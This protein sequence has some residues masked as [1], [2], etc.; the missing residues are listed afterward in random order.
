MG[1]LGGRYRIEAQLG[2]G[3]MGAVYWATDERTGEA[4]AVKRMLLERTRTARKAILRFQ[5]EF[6]TLASLR[7]PRV[8]RA[9]DYGVDGAGPYYTME[10]L[11]GEDLRDVMK[12]RGPLPPREVCRILRDVA[13]ALAALHARGLIH[14]DL[15]PRNVRVVDGRAVLFDFGVLVNAGWVGDVAG[16]PAFVAPEML[17]GVPVDGRADLYSLGVL[18]YGMLTGQ[19]PYDARSLADLEEAWTHPVAPPSAFADVPEALEDLVLDLLCLEP[20]GRPPSAAVLIDRLTSLGDLEADPELAVSPGYVESAAMVGRDAELRTLATLLDEVQ[21][22]VSRAFLVEADSGAGKSRLLQEVAIRAKL[23]GALALR[24]DCEHAEGGPFAAV[25]AIVDE[26]FG[27]DPERAAAATREGAPWLGRVFE[28][29]RRAHPDVALERESGEPAEDR[30][31]LSAAV[32]GALRRLADERPVA[33]LVD[34]VQRCDEASAAL[35]AGLARDGAPGMLLGFA[36]RLGESMRA[37]AAVASLGELE[38]RL[39][40]A[41]LDASGVEALLRSV[42]GDAPRLPRLSRWMLRATGGSPLFCT[43]LTRHLI[44]AGVV[45]YDDG[46]WIVPDELTQSGLP[47]GLAEAMRQRIDG[48]SP[49]SRQV[50]EVLAVHGGEVDLER[51]LGLVDGSVDLPDEEAAPVVFGAL[52]EM[53]QQGVLSDG[54]ERLSFRHDSLREAVLAG[55]A[56]ERRRA[57]HRHVGGVLLEAERHRDDP[58]A[59]AEAGWHLY[60]GGDEEGGAAMLERAGRR[61]YEAQALTDCIAPL[62][63]ALEVR[64]RAGAPDAVIAD[65]SFM[66]LSAGWVSDREVGARHADRAVELCA[67]LG[68]LEHTRRWRRWLGWRL[69]FACALS[70]AGLRWLF[71]W[72]E[73]RGPTPLRAV[74]LFA[75]GMTYATALAYAANQK[76]EVHR[77]IERAAPFRAFEGHPPVAA[78]L[79]VQAMGDILDGRLEL[80]STRLTEAHRLATRAHVNPLTEDERRLSDAAV[81]SIRTIVDVNQFD[82]RLYD[83][84]AALEAS[85]LE[86]YQLVAR[87]L[88]AVRHRYRGEEAKARALEEQM[89]AQELQLGA[90]SVRLQRLLFA[91]P[92]Y[93]FTHD[94]EGLKRA[95]AGLERRVAEGMELSARVAITRAELHRERSELDEALAILEPLHASLDPDDVLMRQYVASSA[96]QAALEAYR[97]E[98]AARYAREGLEVGRDPARRIL[99]PWLRCQ[100][101]LALVEDALGRPDDAGARLERAIDAAERKDCPV[102]AGELHEARARVAFA[103]GDRVLFEVHRDKCAAW[104]R[105]TENPGLIAVVERLVEL[106]REAA[107]RPVDPR[108]RRPGASS[109]E[110]SAVSGT[111]SSRTPR[112]T[113]PDADT[114]V[115]GA[116]GDDDRTVASSPRARRASDASHDAVAADSRSPAD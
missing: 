6:H 4:V 73:A 38:P 28:A 56:P 35:L 79:T 63:T 85:G 43:E 67:W 95:L 5:R 116:N 57:L 29:V 72:G 9:Y 46:T 20:L 34:D 59:E 64:E 112:S 74:S 30:M 47:E 76:E 107:V 60:R 98:Q 84:L 89:E 110:T 61:L 51:A 19:R 114:V 111:R 22:G 109:T 17:R 81:R 102:F 55:L 39:C 70:W 7:H 97:Y 88:R 58:V 50:A 12:A 80:A 45:R 31:R 68:G 106:D 40:L 54:G 10:L 41:G 52:G 16:T 101:V 27:A 25:A 13:S 14:R 32:G 1:A 83:D 90:W 15:S 44:E 24:V 18:A 92:A 75:V 36:R 3:G 71:R 91:H 87:S 99:L 8:I 48:L 105:P 77:S 42:F 86:Y 78:Y 113:R 66:L 100:R 108:R 69:A 94:V 37:P 53:A 26:A 11:E 115:E 65:L 103:A 23:G 21:D 33:V 96:A 82:P 62:E 104:L 93:A 49:R 2:E